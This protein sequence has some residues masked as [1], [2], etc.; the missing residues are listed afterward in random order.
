[1]CSGPA[2]K[3]CDRLVLD[4]DRRILKAQ[5]VFERCLDGA[6]QQTPDRGVPVQGR[7]HQPVAQMEVGLPVDGVVLVAPGH[8]PDR[9]SRHGHRA[10]AVLAGA[11]AV[12]GV[13]PLDEQRQRLAQFLGHPARDHAH[14]PAVVVDVDAP[15]QQ[16]GC[17][18]PRRRRPADTWR[19]RGRTRCAGAL[20]HMKLARLTTSPM[21][22]RCEGSCRLSI[23]PPIRVGVLANRFSASARRIESGSMRMSSSMNRICSQSVLLQRLVHHP[24]VAAGAAEV[25][26]VVDRQ[27]VAQSGGRRGEVGMVHGLVG[28]LIDDD[29]RTDDLVHQGI[30]GQRLQR[31]DAVGRPVE[32]RDAD[33]DVGPPGCRAPGRTRPRC[34]RRSWCR[35]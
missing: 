8:V 29:D 9:G 19:S 5:K 27:P 11:Q 3:S 17:G 23:C 6:L 12:V 4:R 35:W 1:M 22:C 7:D 25:G 14:P 18:P 24:A 16:L 34:A 2:R 20:V 10:V 26:L 13:V 28:A 31:V 30:R 32:G 15:V 21:T 33:G